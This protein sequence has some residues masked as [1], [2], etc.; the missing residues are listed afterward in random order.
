MECFI[1]VYIFIEI[2][3]F[4]STNIK[5]LLY[6][7]KLNIKAMKGD[8]FFAFLGG[9][10]IGAAAAILFAP[11]SGDETRKKIK[12]TFEKEYD[13]IKTKIKKEAKEAAE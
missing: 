5:K 11:S 4:I 9:A 13:N 10:I 7:L 3:L 2:Q 12:D 6:L 1:A 8:T